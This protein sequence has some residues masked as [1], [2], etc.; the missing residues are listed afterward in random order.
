M[1]AT[2]ITPQL[3]VISTS[4]A[5]LYLWEENHELTLID[6]G[7]PK[8]LP[9]LTNAITSLGHSITNLTTVILTHFHV[10]HAGASAELADHGTTICASTTETP[11]ITGDTPQP[12]PNLEQ[13]ELPLWN[14]LPPEVLNASTPPSP[15]HQQLNDGDTVGP[16][17]ILTTP[18][19]TPGSIAIY[20]PQQRIL[21]TG[22]TLAN[23]DNTPT[24]GVFNTHPELLTT[25]LKRLADL[26]VTMICPG[27][28][29]IITKNPQHALTKLAQ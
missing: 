9:A 27:H 14:S 7:I 23:V 15:I 13:W 29:N 4:H 8:N 28:G 5:P 1:S 12:A 19:H 26:D 11:Y 10:D 24:R 3:S 21:F 17:R 22:D 20:H 18:G 6:C 2:T 16:F 25:S